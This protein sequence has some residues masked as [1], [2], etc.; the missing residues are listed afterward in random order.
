[1]GKRQTPFSR[2]IPPISSKEEDRVPVTIGLPLP[3][4]SLDRIGVLYK[5]K[6]INVKFP[7]PLQ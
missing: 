6:S 7:V 3:G 1:M 5:M 4:L 2:T